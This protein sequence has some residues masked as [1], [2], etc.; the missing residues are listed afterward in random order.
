MSRP[1]DLPVDM[2]RAS[3]ADAPG[4]GLRL[5]EELHHAPDWDD[6]SELAAVL[7][8]LGGLMTEPLPS[9]QDAAEAMAAQMATLLRCP[10]ELPR[11]RSLAGRRRARIAAVVVAASMVAT[12]GLA[13][14]DV[15]P[16]PAQRMASEVLERFGIS[17]PGA[18]RDGG[19]GLEHRS[20]T[21]RDI[22][23]ERHEPASGDVPAMD[24]IID[25]EGGPMAGDTPATTAPGAPLLLGDAPRAGTTS[26]YPESGGPGG[27]WENDS[28]TDLGTTYS[29]DS[30]WARPGDPAADATA[31]SA[32][33]PDD[34]GPTSPPPDEPASTTPESW[35]ADPS[36][37][38][39]TPTSRDAAS[40]ADPTRSS[41]AEPPMTSEPTP[42]PTGPGT[43][44]GG[45]TDPARSSGMD[46]SSPPL[47]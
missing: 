29:P 18:E 8:V 9:E 3:A 32:P 35:P 19:P 47:P 23:G 27:S 20:G 25:D 4:T 5:I 11:P 17:V 40:T 2:D 46:R 39:P 24:S 15:L 1:S 6:P 22:D 43:E 42:Q 34:W 44:G 45:S 33:P 36:P 10:A 7:E 31:P 38:S 30:E 14:A 12:T 21:S 26:E 16:D 28:A 37:A 13:A 41:T